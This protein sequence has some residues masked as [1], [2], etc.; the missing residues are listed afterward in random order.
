M[1]EI[2]RRVER[3]RALYLGQL[4]VRAKVGVPAW[5]KR[6]K[7][8]VNNLERIAN[9]VVLLVQRAEACQQAVIDALGEQHLV[10]RVELFEVLLIDQSQRLV[11]L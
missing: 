3:L 10:E 4:L 9:K 7:F 8:V 6:R 5:A 2:E 1:G 11:E